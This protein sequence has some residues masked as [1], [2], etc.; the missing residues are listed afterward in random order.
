MLLH[1]TVYP[2]FLYTMYS[3]QNTTR[4]LMVVLDSSLWLQNDGVPTDFLCANT[5]SRKLVT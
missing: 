1:N 5:S 3:L 2:R 4:T